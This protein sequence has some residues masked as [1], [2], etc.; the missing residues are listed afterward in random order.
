MLFQVFKKVMSKTL[1]F[2]NINIILISV[3]ENQCGELNIFEKTFA[4]FNVVLV[5]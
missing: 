4:Q 3:T 1:Y 2:L 5:L